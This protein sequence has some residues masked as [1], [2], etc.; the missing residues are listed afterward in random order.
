MKEIKK[1]E[2]AFM[3]FDQNLEWFS[4]KAKS[5]SVEVIKRSETAADDE[6]R[7]A[8]I[9]ELHAS[10]EKAL[11]EHKRMLLDK[12]CQFNAK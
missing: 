12:E 8:Q 4:I 5:L 7:I 9:S 1:K 10:N 3:P 11:S 2:E 6:R